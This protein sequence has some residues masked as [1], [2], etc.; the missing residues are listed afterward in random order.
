MM[1]TVRIK[2][3]LC[4]CFLL[5]TEVCIALFVRD[6]FVRP[7]VGD[8][9]VTVLICAFARIFIPRGVKFLPLYVFIFSALVEALQYFDIVKL[10]GLEGSRFLSVL[11]GRTFSAADL[12]CYA[13]GSALFFAVEY[14]FNHK[15]L[16]GK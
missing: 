6:A 9:L 13:I 14:L 12:A 16:R 3:A 8:M 5:I 7:Y 11:I 10:L 2:Y 1:K 15:P 4:F